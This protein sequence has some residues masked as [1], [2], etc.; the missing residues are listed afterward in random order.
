M[1]FGEHAVGGQAGS[2]NTMCSRSPLSNT[3]RPLGG[4]V[5]VRQRTAGAGAGMVLR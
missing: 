4:G 1:D 3:T 2:E 5:I